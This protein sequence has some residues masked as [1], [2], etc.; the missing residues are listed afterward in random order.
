MFSFSGL[1]TEQVE[2]LREKYAIYIV[3]G[4]RINVAG[5]TSTNLEYFCE[6]VA[7]VL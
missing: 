7:A 1:G 5:L 4:G 3:G 2:A 6:S